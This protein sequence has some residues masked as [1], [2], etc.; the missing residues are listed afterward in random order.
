MY[1]IL[2]DSLPTYGPLLLLGIALGL[3]IYRR[4]ARRMPLD[5]ENSTD[6]ILLIILL[7]FAGA[8]LLHV[9]VMHD[10]YLTSIEGVIRIG[11]LWDGGFAYVGG[12]LAGS[13][14]LL[15]LR[16]R[17]PLALTAD[18]MVIPLAFTHFVGRLGCFSAGCCHGKADPPGLLGVRF[19]P[20][21]AAA[22]WC[23]GGTSGECLNHT[24]F[25]ATQLYEALGILLI[26]IF[27][28]L[29]TP[30]K[31]FH[32]H[33]TALYL[34][35]YGG[36]RFFVEIFRGDPT[37]GFLMEINTPTLNRFL[38]LPAGEPLFFSTSQMVSLVL[39]GCA[40]WILWYNF[41]RKPN[42]RSES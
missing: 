9:V 38:G 36:V 12:V 11:R 25:H 10:L 37:R 15:L 18:L 17:L 28:A 29:Y 4:G 13:V 3:F 6:F 40:L 31:R 24:F 20:H 42:Q 8:R 39:M 5:V 34:L 30:R 22:A 23:P 7:G 27:L 1:P 19:S 32:G 16:K 33:M 35:A 2:F 26:I 41:S 21:G 14:S